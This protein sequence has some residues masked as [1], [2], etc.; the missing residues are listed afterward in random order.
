LVLALQG[1]GADGVVQVVAV[2]LG[3]LAA[4]VVSLGMTAMVQLTGERLFPQMRP[5]SRTAA[6]SAVLF[7]ACLT[8]YVGWFGLFPYVT[9]RGLGAFLLGWWTARNERGP[10]A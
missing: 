10:A 6:G 4:V 9:L 2:V 8:P 1:G 3:I 7:V 5:V